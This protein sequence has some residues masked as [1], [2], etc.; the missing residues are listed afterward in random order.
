EGLQ[1]G[2]GHGGQA[3]RRLPETGAARSAPPLCAPACVPL[4]SLR[5]AT[6]AVARKRR[7]GG[8]GV[9]RRHDSRDEGGRGDARRPAGHARGHPRRGGGQDQRLLRRRR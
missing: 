2:T 7:V 9:A 8:R 5:D 1:S 6:G 3:P 4:P